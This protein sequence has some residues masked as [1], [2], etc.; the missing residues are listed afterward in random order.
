M[1]ALVKIAALVVVAALTVGV[2]AAPAAAEPDMR[3]I[4][5]RLLE[6][7]SNQAEQPNQAEESSQRGKRC[8]A[9]TAPAGNTPPD[10]CSSPYDPPPELPP[11]C[12][13]KLIEVVSFIVR[14]IKRPIY[15]TV[16]AML[17]GTNIPDPNA[18]PVQVITGYYWEPV[19]ERV[20]SA[21]HDYWCRNS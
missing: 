10:T 1:K 6:E 19:K 3:Q 8:V 5:E 11:T 7:Q 20:V 18:S 17:P 21:A 16:Q 15:T 2:A 4:A 14:M 13:W 12:S 9:G